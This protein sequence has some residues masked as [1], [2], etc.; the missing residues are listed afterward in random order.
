MKSHPIQFRNSFIYTIVIFSLLLA[1]IYMNDCRCYSGMFFYNTGDIVKTIAILFPTICFE[2][3]FV[4]CCIVGI[5]KIKTSETP[6]KIS[7]LMALASLVVILLYVINIQVVVIKGYSTDLFEQNWEDVKNSYLNERY[8][9]NQHVTLSMGYIPNIQF[10]PFYVAQQKGIFADYSLEV[11][12]DYG[13]APD[14]VQLVAAGQKQFAITD[15][16]QV[17]LARQQAMPVTSVLAYYQKVPIS[18]VTLKTSDI[19][20]PNDLVGKKIGIPGLYGSSY[21]SLLAFLADQNIPTDSLTIESIGYTQVESLASGITQAVVVF[22]NNEPVLLQDLGYEINE[23]ILSDYISLAGASLITNEQTIDES[24]QL[25]Q[26]VVQSIA[27]AMLYTSQNP[28]EAFDIAVSQIPD[29]APD[30]YATQ[31]KILDKTIEVWQ[32][33]EVSGFGYHDPDIWAATQEQMKTIELLPQ[34][35]NLLQEAFTSYYLSD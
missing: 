11:E 28:D 29:L 13:I 7:I 15:G 17:L 3:A 12:F 9:E 27:K 20:Q 25:V 2:I 24:P 21:T 14:L 22:S 30:D 31:R 16:E 35:S 5:L 23:I 26:A 8:T 10:T 18:I 33:P 1:T 4:V 6:K 34:D 32:N 19:S